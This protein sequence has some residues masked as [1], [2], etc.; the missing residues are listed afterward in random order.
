MA[1]KKQLKKDI[2][3][4]VGALIEEI[5][6]WELMNPKGDFKKSEKL[7]DEAIV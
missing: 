6:V 5:Y 7:I 3:N 4:S 2:N 1:S